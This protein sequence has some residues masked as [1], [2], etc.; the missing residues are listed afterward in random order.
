MT[1]LEKRPEWLIFNRFLLHAFILS[2]W[3]IDGRNQANGYEKGR[4][5]MWKWIKISGTFWSLWALKTVR[6]QNALFSFS[7][8]PQQV[9]NFRL[10]SCLKKSWLMLRR[11]MKI[12]TEFKQN[13]QRILELWTWRIL[14]QN[15]IQ[16]NFPSEE[17]STNAKFLTQTFME[18]FE[19]VVTEKHEI[20]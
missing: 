7:D 5:W 18:L 16:T 3:N 11:K 6:E 20:L 4:V 15:L 9:Q 17:S 2:D 14:M 13:C 8:R 12:N 10:G 19:H 1:T